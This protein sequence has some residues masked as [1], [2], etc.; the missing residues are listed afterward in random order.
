MDNVS[1]RTRSKNKERTSAPKEQVAA[2]LTS[3]TLALPHL[4]RHSSTQAPQRQYPLDD[5]SSVPQTR[6][7][8][9]DE[10]T[11]AAACPSAASARR[12]RPETAAQPSPPLPSRSRC[13]H[14]LGPDLGCT[15]HPRHRPCPHLL[16]ERPWHCW[17]PD[18]DR[19]RGTLEYPQPPPQSRDH[20]LPWGW[21][22]RYHESLETRNC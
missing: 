18:P 21:R 2:C 5:S 3:K 22:L 6:R 15:L 13:A 1:K 12:G 20:R 8:T 19:K 14:R 7:H 11:P 10:T 4:S 17:Q 16:A 9:S